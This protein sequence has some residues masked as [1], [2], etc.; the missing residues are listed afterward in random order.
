MINFSDKTNFLWSMADLLRD[1]FKRSQYQDVILPFTV[2]RRIDWVLEPT[3]EQV[4]ETYYQFRDDTNLLD[5]YL[6]QA[7]GFAFYNLSPYTFRK[8]IEKPQNLAANLGAYIDGFSLNMR[9]VLANYDIKNTIFKLEK[10]GLLFLIMDKFYHLDLHPERV[11]NIEMGYIFEDLIRRFNEALNENPGEHF[12]PRE[13][14]RLMFSLLYSPHKKDILKDKITYSIYDPCCGSGGMLTTAKNMLSQLNNKA[15]IQLFGQ[16]VNPETF[17]VCKSDLYLTSADGEDAEN[18]YFG[19]TLADD[20][21][22]GKTFDYMLSNPPYGK[23]WKADEDVVKAE[24]ARGFAGRFG[25]GYPRINDGQL[26]FLQHMLSKMKPLAEGGSR[27]AIITNGSPLFTGDA[28]SGESEIRRWIIENDWLEAVIALPEQLFYNT[29]IATYIW[30]LTNKKARKR[31]G[32]VQLIMAQDFFSPINKSLGDKRR[33]ITSLQAN[34][35]LTLYE[36]FT[37]GKYCNIFN[38]SDFGYRKIIIERPLRVNYQASPQRI[39]SLTK[40]RVFRNLATS[41]RHSPEEEA[42][43]SR[44]QRS[45]LAVLNS[46]PEEKFTDRK[47]FEKLVETALE[48]AGIKT[49]ATLFRTIINSLTKK[50]KTAP[51]IIDDQGNLK[52][53]PKLKDTENVP[54]YEDV[55]A[56]FNKKVKPR[57]PDAWLNEDFIDGQDKQIGKVGYEINFNHY[58]CEYKAPRPLLEVETELKQLEEEIRKLFQEMLS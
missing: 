29:A 11:S 23:E 53:D 44:L 42:E 19:S 26:L 52:A 49:N 13:V 3:K 32:K 8:L 4:L 43:G 31:Q 30:I 28:G 15:V 2:L 17:A 54:L 56:Y 50:D 33:E 5:Q 21:H 55:Y 46:L 22:A 37:E 6:C 20:K 27:I 58:F 36:A 24:Y 12:T 47:K 16:E 51:P 7:S 45:I 10:A 9:E 57:V 38:N 34:E 39:E 41:K 25:A 18:I 35:I 48:S 1:H 14:I 40:N